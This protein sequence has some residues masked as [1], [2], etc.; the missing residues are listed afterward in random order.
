MDIDIAEPRVAKSRRNTSGAG[1]RWPICSPA[2]E[3]SGSCLGLTFFDC[4]NFIP[5]NG[6]LERDA[7]QLHRLIGDLREVPVRSGVPP[8][9]AA[10][11]GGVAAI[12]AEC[13][14]ALARATCHVC[15]AHGRIH[16]IPAPSPA[17]KEKLDCANECQPG[18]RLNCKVPVDLSSQRITVAIPETQY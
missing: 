15:V 9:R 1:S 11:D 18:S 2:D 5:S 16:R 8:T 6:I 3:A 17:D 10:L 12:L 7:P 4:R 14:D 13:D